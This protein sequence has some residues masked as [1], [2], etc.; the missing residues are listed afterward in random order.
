MERVQRGLECDM[1]RLDWWI[2]LRGLAW[3]LACAGALGAAC[4]PGPA[5]PVGPR[6]PT[7]ATGAAPEVRTMSC[8]GEQPSGTLWTYR[9]AEMAGEL[10]MAS[11]AVHV[12]PDAT[13][14]DTVF[15]EPTQ[16]GFA[17]AACVFQ[18]GGQIICSL[19]GGGGSCLWA[20]TGGGGAVLVAMECSGAL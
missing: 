15:Y 4:A 9:V 16:A 1:V 5:G 3:L 8:L 19:A 10:R 11:C 2:R 17:S 13:Y 20:K 6:G 12:V 14:G 7:G 18:Y